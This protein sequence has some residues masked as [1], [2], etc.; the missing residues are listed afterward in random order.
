MANYRAFQ[1]I[2]LGFLCIGVSELILR[3]LVAGSQ[4]GLAIGVVTLIASACCFWEAYSQWRAAKQ[5]L[6]EIRRQAAS[7]PEPRRVP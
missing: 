1:I 6:D 5:R 2:G 4:A 7:E 3:G